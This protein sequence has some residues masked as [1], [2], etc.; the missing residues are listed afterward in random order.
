MSDD[1][2][3]RSVPTSQVNVDALRRYLDGTHREIREEVRR[4]MAE[5]QFALPPPDMPRAE[6]REQVLKWARQLASAHDT[7]IGYPRE[8]GGEGNAGG[9]IASFEMLGHS[10]L[11]LL[12]KVGVQ[13]GL[14][15]GAILH[16]GT[17]K[18]HE[19]YLADVATLDLPGCFAMSEAGHGS[20][21][22]NLQTTAT[23]DHESR[24]LVVNTP[25]EDDHKDWIGNAADHGRMAAVFCQLVVGGESH[26]IHCVL[27]P[28]RDDRMK[29]LPGIRIEDCGPK[30]GLNGVDNGRIWFDDVRVPVDN[31][32]DQHAQITD[33]GRYHSPIEDPDRRFFTMLGTLVQGRVSVGG[34]GLSAAKSA[35]AIAI[36]YG[37][38]R[39][40]FGPP[41]GSYEAPLLDYRTHQRR[42]LPRLA[43]TYALHFSQQELTDEF[44]R[45]FTNTDVDTLDRTPEDE[46]DRRRLESWAA[47]LK[48]ANTWHATDCIQE[49]REA[50]GGQGYLTKN[51]FAALKADTDVFTTFEGDNTVLM[52]LVAKSLVSQFQAD[53]GKLDPLEMFGYVS[54]QVLEQVVERASLRQVV[55]RLADAVPG[56]DD[57]AGLLDTD[58]HLEMFRWREEHVL[59]GL[60]RRLRDRIES[61]MDPYEAFL[62]CQDH[63]VHA[64]TVHV[65]RYLMEAFARGVEH[66]D[67]P[68]LKPALER[69]C[70]LFA[71]SE[72]EADRGWFQEHGRLSGERS[73]AVINA[74]NRLVTEVRPDAVALV[75]A[76]GI[77]EEVLAPIAFD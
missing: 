68:D 15:G 50:C 67:D 31:L 40:Q 42:L 12:V 69:L 1:T 10:D 2:A 19:A 13:F 61:D 48:A 60:M 46:Q 23:Y 76:F 25:T 64:A 71:L 39:R 70:H 4:K 43:R 52:Q 65:E 20:D 77:P 55:E 38:R 28:L 54:G 30:M 7:A 5:P 9:S 14:F 74:V 27:V 51:R 53:F 22:Q 11:S 6:Y 37:E 3:T 32:L 58:Y 62:E 17:R 47:G 66:C 34:A 21:V 16:L 36:R 44:H 35:M 45:I 24:E 33:D 49:S 75:D 26:G 29:V 63:V 56:R 41:D 8:F 72:I 57:D 59:S 18:H 73:K